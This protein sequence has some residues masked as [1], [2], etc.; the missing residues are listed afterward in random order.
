MVVVSKQLFDAACR[1]V[2]CSV[3]TH[4]W[5]ESCLK[6]CPGLYKDAVI[7]SAKFYSIIYIAQ[8]L[9]RGKKMMKKDQWIKMGEYYVRSTMLG[10]M[11]TSVAPNISCFIR[12]M[13]GDRFYPS[14]YLFIPFAVCGLFIY[15]EPPSRR[16]LVINLFCNLGRLTAFVTFLDSLKD[17]VL[18]SCDVSELQ[19]RMGKMESL[20]EQ[21][22]E[23]Q[24][25]L[26][27]IA[28]DLKVQNSE[29]TEFESLYYKALSRA[30]IILNDRLID[31]L[32]KDL[33]ALESLGEPVKHWDTFLI[34]H[35][36][37]K[38][39]HRTY[40]EWEE[41]KGRIDK[42]S[43][44]TFDM[45]MQFLRTRADLIENLERLRTNNNSQTAGRSNP[46]IKSMLVN[47][48]HNS[49]S[50]ETAPKVC[51]KC[52]SND[53]QLNN[54]PQFLALSVDARIKL[55]PTYKICFNC[56]RSGHFAN[57]CKKAG[58]K[59]CKRRHNT[60]IHVDSTDK[61]IAN[62]HSGNSSNN[63]LSSSSV[64]SAT[65]VANN[66]T[67]SAHIASSQGHTQRDVLLSTALIK[68]RDHTGC[69]HVVRSVLDSGSTS[70]FI[71]E[72]LCKKLN[73]FTSQ[74]I[75]Y[76]IK[77]L[78]RAGFPSVT[79]THQTLMF[80]LGSSL[81]FYLMRL[82][83][84]KKER[85]PL[86]FTPE[87]VKRK[88]IESESPCPHKGKCEKY[89]AKGFATY[90]GVGLGISLA[91][92]ILPKISTPIR[93]I[94]SIRSKHFKL[95]MFFGSYIGIYRAVVCYL[96]RKK[97]F[98]SALYALPAG[99]AAGISFLFNPSLGLS[100]ASL[101]AA[102]KL[103][104]TILYEKKILPSNIPLPELLYCFCQGTLFNARIL[105][106]DACP[107]YVFNLMK[108]CSNGRFVL[109]F[110]QWYKIDFCVL[111]SILWFFKLAFT[112]LI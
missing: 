65:T 18:S 54:C 50:I 29:R 112:I 110:L 46:K 19:L 103:Y 86:L 28:D 14:T 26:E 61:I 82:E 109:I 64:P 76:Y 55:L 90:F 104:S 100:I 77:V 43:S 3:M 30:Q 108:S 31:Q 94:S 56:L 32:N 33:R 107:S 48:P 72:R 13:L 25:R 20:Y 89:V 92:L 98:D 68:L 96:C 9:M 34:Y 81:L 97:G 60:L 67:L 84:D 15:L 69:V 63:N 74:V 11:V 79:R 102:F 8:I 38:I 91:R 44:I 66:V 4:P 73:L 105:D 88:T 41:F 2:H 71:T 12:K 75:E 22:D 51:P 70:S 93:A 99:Y 24:L 106:P 49:S 53:H 45:F 23:V 39:D 80:M 1:D 40:R 5:N 36:T 59:L 83:G 37:Q 85:T 16:G 57:K 62:T 21:Y 78:E 17:K 47:Q 58:C 52:H 101:T 7:G 35:V 10:L 6:A 27:C 42:E 111:I 95:A 87:K